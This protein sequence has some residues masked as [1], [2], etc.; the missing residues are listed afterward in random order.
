MTTRA[1]LAVN[2]AKLVGGDIL[3]ITEPGTGWPAL[4]TLII[5]SSVVPV[6]LFVAPIT[7]SH[8]SRDDVER[9]F[10]NPGQNRPII[11]PPDRQPLLLGIYEEDPQLDVPRP[12]LIQ[13]DPLLR[14]GRT[15]RY[16]VFVSLATIRE[17]WVKGW[18]EEVNAAGE[19]IRCLT[20]PLLPVSVSAVVDS[21]VPDSEL[22]QAAVSGSGLMESDEKD[23]PAA[24]RARRAGSSLV[25]DARFRRRVT[26]AYDCRCAM[27]GID[28]NLIQAAHI[29]PAA[30]PGSQDEPWN[31]LALC[32]NHHAAFDQHLLAVHP[33]DKTI[34]Y[35]PTI[36][37]DAESSPAMAAFVSATFGSLA[38]PREPAS[39]P[40]EEMFTRR[41]EHFR[42]YYDW[43]TVDVMHGP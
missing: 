41:Y 17:A 11:L 40:R 27:C 16:S 25:R 4:G 1:E 33:E 12:L 37:S 2:L 7:L 42:G 39:L 9:R 22:M 43:L 38:Q 15:T 21:A 18:A 30:A 14:E 36:K 13:A 6:S 35:S 26:T 3:K 5:D 23:A 20:P 8:R 24:E 28:A 32:P 29:Y 31:G 34:I 19:R 10:Q